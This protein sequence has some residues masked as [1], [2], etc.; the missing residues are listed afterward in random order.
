[1]QVSTCKKKEM[2]MRIK[3]IKIDFQVTPEIERFVYVYLIETNNGC[4]LID[5]GV[6]GSE[7]KIE[8]AILESGHHPSE[9]K[10][11]FLTHAHP[12]HIGT[13]H[14]FRENMGRKYMPA[15]GNVHG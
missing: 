5:S 1:M 3:Q 2:N 7:T 4:V 12:D 13:A 15:K 8:R 10:A 14:Y 11:I 9:T 6:A